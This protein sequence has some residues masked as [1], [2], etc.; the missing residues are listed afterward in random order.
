M[1]TTQHPHNVPHAAPRFRLPDRA[2]LGYIC[3]SA[4][5]PYL[6]ACILLAF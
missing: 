2:E 3:A 1:N 4:L 5:M 6:L